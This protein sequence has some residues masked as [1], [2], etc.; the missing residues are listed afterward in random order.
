MGHAG[1]IVSGGKGTA[2]GK[3]EALAAAGVRISRHLDHREVPLQGDE[4]CGSS[5]KVNTKD[6]SKIQENYSEIF[7]WK[8]E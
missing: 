7:V 6:K 4:E 1:S 5:L 8:L 2:E 3:Y